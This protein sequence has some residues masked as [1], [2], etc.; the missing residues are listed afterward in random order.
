MFV[1]TA[2]LQLFLFP[3]FAVLARAILVAA[4]I[5][6]DGDPRLVAGALSS[7]VVGSLVTVFPALIGVIIGWF[8]LRRQRDVPPWFLRFSSVMSWFW[9]LF[10]PLGTLV[11]AL[12]LRVLKKRRVA[13]SMGMVSR[14]AEQGQ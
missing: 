10:L 4:S 12:Q 13:Q 14:A 5:Y 3:A 11:G 7:G 2:V 9:L 1:V 6:S 8:L